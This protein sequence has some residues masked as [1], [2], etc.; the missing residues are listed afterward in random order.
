MLPYLDDLPSIVFVEEPE[1][2]IHPQ[3][4]E[5]VLQSL[6][7]AYNSQVLIGSHSPVV[8]ANSKREQ[9]LCFQLR[10]DGATTIVSGNDHPRLKNWEG[11]ID[12]GML[13]AS[14][15]MK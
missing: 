2:G 12:L 3:A 9:L 4:I 7:S 10:K 6:S 15:V 5:L 8:L 11:A 14:G 1:N 13:F